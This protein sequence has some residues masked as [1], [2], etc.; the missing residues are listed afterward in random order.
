MV[1]K[2]VAVLGSTGSIGRQ[3][4]DVLSRWPDRFEVV[5]LTCHSNTDGFA[6]QLAQVKPR[7][8]VAGSDDHYNRLQ[9]L[10]AKHDNQPHWLLGEAGLETLCGVA[11]IDIVIVG[12]VGYAGLKPTL[13]ALQTGKRVLTAN[14]ETFV[15]AGHLVA[16]YLS[17]IVPL[18]SEHSAIF[19][20]LQSCWSA[21]NEV[22]T[23]YITASGG[24]FWN[25]PL[26]QLREVTVE[27]ALNHPTWQMGPKVTIDSATMM[28]KGFECIEASV[29][30][31]M[32]LSRIE[33][34]IHPQSI[35]HSAVAFKDGALLAQMGQPDMRV[36]IQYGLSYPTRWALDED[37]QEQVH[38]DLT[39]L[40]QLTFYPADDNRFPC[41]RLA[42]WAGEEG[43][44][45]PVVL[46]AADEVAVELFLAHQLPFTA[47]A[48]LIEQVMCNFPAHDYPSPSL[49][50]I[51]EIDAWARRQA[52]SLARQLGGTLPVQAADFAHQPVAPYAGVAH[53]GGF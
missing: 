19:Q 42:K 36:P 40:S 53:S 21:D 43:G 22:K 33:P 34:V 23:I 39:R 7:W 4:L 25:T 28:N 49:E 9:S 31:N 5:A 12:I 29:L 41:L 46:N 47:I 13:K 8:A 37:N 26:E 2:R 3:A 30:F 45:L 27:A 1:R 52:L 38:L 16:P 15:V 24:P 32:P 6:R 20:C 17:Q 51:M 35:V 14:K 50:T 10:T 18:D 11:D 48:P 44:G